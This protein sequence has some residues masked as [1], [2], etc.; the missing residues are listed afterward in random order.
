MRSIVLQPLAWMVAVMD[1][2]GVMDDTSIVVDC[3]WPSHAKQALYGSE[4]ERERE[5]K[6]AERQRKEAERKRCLLG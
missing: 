5:E 2:K 4:R 6:E 3:A 1:R